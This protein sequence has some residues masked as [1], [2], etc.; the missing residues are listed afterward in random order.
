M[1]KSVWVFIPMRI[2]ATFNLPLSQQ[3]QQKPLPK[4]EVV[5]YYSSTTTKS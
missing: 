5:H 3:K 2:F 1:Q 4:L